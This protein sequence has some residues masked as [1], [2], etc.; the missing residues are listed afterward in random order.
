MQITT[1]MIKQF[2]LLIGTTLYILLSM[3][4]NPLYDKLIQDLE[5]DVKKIS[6][7]IPVRIDDSFDVE[8]IA[9]EDERDDGL[10]FDEVTIIEILKRLPSDRYRIVFLF[11]LLNQLGYCFKGQDIANVWGITSEAIYQ[12]IKSMGIILRKKNIEDII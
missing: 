5:A 7:K 6:L 4:S 9:D 8:S 10:V 1:L 3:S 2:D 11:V 12:R